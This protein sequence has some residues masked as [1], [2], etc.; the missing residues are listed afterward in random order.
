MQHS[1]H[2]VACTSGKNKPL[3]PA[4][5][6]VQWHRYSAL[7][8]D[9]LEGQKFLQP[10]LRGLTLFGIELAKFMPKEHLGG[11]QRREGQQLHDSISSKQDIKNW[12]KVMQRDLGK[13][14]VK[15]SLPETEKVLEIGNTLLMQNGHFNQNQIVEQF[16]PRMLSKTIEQSASKEWR[17]I[18]GCNTKRG[19]P[20][21]SLT[22]SSERDHE[23]A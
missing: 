6:P 18:A 13:E 4:P 14:T 7:G 19:R 10:S 21:K 11:K 23:R 2:R 20:A 15:K 22:G 3:S 17:G 9:I 12:L 5:G 16:A 1:T 8:W